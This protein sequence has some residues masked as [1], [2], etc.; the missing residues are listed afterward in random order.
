M[1]TIANLVVEI[2]GKS[3]SLRKELSKSK[4]GVSKFSTTS[5]KSL[6]SVEDSARSLKSAFLGLASAAAALAAIKQVVSVGRDFSESIADLSA[7]TGATGADLKFLSDASREFGKTTT[8][9][10]REVATAFKL[11]ASAKPDL[12]T[13]VDALKQV[14]KE[15]IALAEATGTSVPQAAATL[16]SALN[17]F[18]AG[19]NQASRFV[20]VLAAG[21]QKGSSEVADTAQALKLAGVFASKAGLSF[22]ETNAALQTLSR[23]SIKGSLAGTGLK[24]VLTVLQTKVV[25]EFNP[26]LVG[27]AKALENLGK[28]NLSTTQLVDLFGRESLIAAQVLIQSSEAFRTLTEEVTGTKLAYEQAEIKANSFSGKVK[29]M[30]SALE[31]AAITIFKEMEPALLRFVE[32]LTELIR[33]AEKNKDTLA[34]FAL[35][36]GKGGALVAGVI[37]LKIAVGLASLSIKALGVAAAT[38]VGPMTALANSGKLMVSAFV[39]FQI[40]KFL[41]ENFLEARLAGL[42]FVEATLVGWQFLKSGILSAWE[43]IK[44]G[45]LA[46]LEGMQNAFGNFISQVGSLLS[47]VPGLEDIGRSFD[48]FRVVLQANNTAAAELDAKLIS[49][50]DSRVDE[51]N[52]IREHIRALADFEIQADAA[53]KATELTPTTAATPEKR[54]PVSRTVTLKDVQNL[55]K[56][57]RQAVTVNINA[58]PKIRELI[59]FTMENPSFKPVVAEIAQEQVQDS[60]R[61]SRD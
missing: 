57:N 40:G 26:A 29:S 32:K 55:L 1:A 54:T 28:A 25:R 35:I 20:N 18:G 17:Q 22:E 24:N 27:M 23:F 38:S 6:K 51:I 41:R 5:Q 15:A 52:K 47:K 12:L 48:E 61:A 16:G 42:A 9:S 3:S 59:N 39:G 10:A 11:V 19:A 37:A 30:N 44:N 7:I 43:I 50:T 13:N 60:A 34:R 4:A 56:G 8:L 33:V 46:A 36:V 49:L 31:G 53:N 2:E 45:W 58:D 14:T 21:A